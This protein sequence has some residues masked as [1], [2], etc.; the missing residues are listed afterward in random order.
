MSIQMKGWYM[1]ENKLTWLHDDC[2]ELRGETRQ[3]V[4]PNLLPEEFDKEAA[5]EGCN[6]NPGGH[7]WYW[8]QEENQWSYLCSDCTNYRQVVEVKPEQ[9][10][11]ANGDP[12]KNIRLC[13]RCKDDYHTYL[14]LEHGNP[15]YW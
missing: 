9:K 6:D 8:D 14:M 5:C 11:G 3:V 4:N 2:A 1:I 12:N 15:A 10:P 13:D 7:D